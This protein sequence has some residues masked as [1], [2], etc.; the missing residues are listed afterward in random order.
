MEDLD[1]LAFIMRRLGTLGVILFGSSFLLYNLAAL[2]GDPLGEL[3]ISQDPRAKQIMIS[4]TRELQLDVP[5][6]LRYFI[7]LSGVLGLFV[8]K[9]DLGTTR[10][11]E[12]VATA[13][14]S[15][16]PTTVRWTG[17][18]SRR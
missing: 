11:G 17:M 18:S 12:S 5:P 7:W 6:P 4:L 3:R 10:S 13:I 1:L 9:L 15:A 2:S 14:A 8:G 16:I